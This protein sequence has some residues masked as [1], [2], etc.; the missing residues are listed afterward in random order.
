[1]SLTCPKC[2]SVIL[3]AD[4]QLLPQRTARCGQCGEVFDF[5][6][7]IP[8]PAPPVEPPRGF[9]VTN[10]LSDLVI[11][12]RWFPQ[13]LF[14]KVV[15]ILNWP[16]C[17]LMYTPVLALLFPQFIF[18]TGPNTN[19]P[20]SQIGFWIALVFFLG[21]AL[22]FTYMMIAWTVNRTEIRISSTAVSV[23]CYPLKWP[24]ESKA[25]STTDIDQPFCSR[26]NSGKGSTSYQVFVLLH[27]GKRI[28]LVTG[29]EKPEH[30]RFI[31]Q[32]IELRFGITDQ[33]VYGEL[34]NF[35]GYD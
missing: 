12:R 14:R 2:G 25:V 9:T 29:L 10:D 8:K 3:P 34:S 32:Q 31:A 13:S 17:L 15:Y 30:A 24:G 18:H 27:S 7:Q 35:E 28:S 21:W 23:C 11:T 6:G 33:P 4:I 16:L 20:V 26:H 5:T 1:M 22:F 19:Q